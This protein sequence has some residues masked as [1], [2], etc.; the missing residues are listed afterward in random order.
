MLA[1]VWA[2]V[3]AVRWFFDKSPYFI[4]YC[5]SSTLLH[6]KLWKSVKRL[7]IYPVRPRLLKWGENREKKW[8]GEK[9]MRMGLLLSISIVRL[10]KKNRKMESAIDMI[11]GL[12]WIDFL[13]YPYP[14]WRI[15]WISYFLSS[16]Y[17]YTFFLPFHHAIWSWNPSH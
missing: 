13:Y 7:N 17:T 9:N 10:W 2:R 11:D 14:H 1:S 16:L 15:I 6:V 12:S 5:I 8:E 3:S 4:G